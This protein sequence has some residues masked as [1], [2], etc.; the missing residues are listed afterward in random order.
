VRLNEPY[1]PKDGVMHTLNLH[2]A[3]RQL[4]HVMVEI[5]NDFIRSERGQQEWA[6]RLSVPL[7]QALVHKGD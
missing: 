5:R 2:A 7:I 4:R 6:Q 3:A 1:G